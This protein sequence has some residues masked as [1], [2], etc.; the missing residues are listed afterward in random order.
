MPSTGPSA[1]RYGRGAMLGAIAGDVIGSP[2]E[3]DPIKTT[4]FPLLGEASRFTDDTVLSVA[5]ADAILGGTPFDAAYRSWYR[6]YPGAGYGGFFHR[7]AASDDLGP[8]NSFGNGSAMR[9]GPVGW[10]FDDLDRVLEVARSSAAVTHDHPEGIRGAQVTAGAVFLARAEPIESV[11][12]WAERFAGYDL[13]T[14]IAELRPGHTFDVTCQGTVPLALR[15]AYEA[16]GFE[17]AV[18]LAVSLGGDADTLAAI[19]GA[20]AEARFGGVPATI[21]AGVVGRLDPTLREVL[22]SFTAAHRVPRPAP[23]PGAS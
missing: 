14:A 4:E 13:G 15:C 10:A 2:Y 20:I 1:V 11:V 17:Q 23:Q 6:R 19:A 18:R 22:D 9:V 5:T 16:D 21:A 3:H 8:Y 12:A 7:W